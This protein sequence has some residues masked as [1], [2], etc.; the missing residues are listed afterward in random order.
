MDAVAEQAEEEM[1]P[2]VGFNSDLMM[3]YLRAT[4]GSEFAKNIEKAMMVDF[5]VNNAV[6]YNLMPSP[7]EQAVVHKEEEKKKKAKKEF[8]EA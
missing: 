4:P 1:T 8:V 6:A 5:V 3:M 7:Y 2:V